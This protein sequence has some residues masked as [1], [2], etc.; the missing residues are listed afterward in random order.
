MIH[1]R[2]I[3]II[4][5]LG[6]LSFYYQLQLWIIGSIISYK[7]FSGHSLLKV[8]SIMDLHLENSSYNNKIY[9]LHYAVRPTSLMLGCVR[10]VINCMDQ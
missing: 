9:N 5:G 6:L 4:G 3:S 8:Y 1:A 10:P 7:E 2:I